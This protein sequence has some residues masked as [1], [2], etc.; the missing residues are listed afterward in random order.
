[1]I[2]R[3]KSALRRFLHDVL[4]WHDGKGAVPMYDGCSF[5]SRCSQCGQ[6]VLLDSQ[7]NWFT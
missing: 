6:R 5:K 2:R 3:L 7:G 1:M 4:G